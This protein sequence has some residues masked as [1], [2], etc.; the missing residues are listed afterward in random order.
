LAVF[1]V[2]YTDTGELGFDADGDGTVD[3]TASIGSGWHSIEIVY[4]VSNDQFTFSVDGAADV[5]VSTTLTDNIVAVRL[6]ALSNAGSGTA[7]FDAF[8][9]R[10]LNRPGRLC[11]GDANNDDEIRSADVLS[12]WAEASSFGAQKA[13]GQPDYNEDGLV[14]TSDVLSMWNNHAAVFNFDCPTP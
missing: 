7:D 3:Q 4:S 12:A 9:S 13:P 2:Y 11:R 1:T 14:R 6:G 5:N 8:D 10:R